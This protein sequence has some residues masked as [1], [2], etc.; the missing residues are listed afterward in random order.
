V[1]RFNA[2][3]NDFAH[4][5]LAEDKNNKIMSFEGMEATEEEIQ[6]SF[7]N[8]DATIDSVDSDGGSAA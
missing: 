2:G 1:S 7:G 3:L 6:E 4:I 5:P 8:E